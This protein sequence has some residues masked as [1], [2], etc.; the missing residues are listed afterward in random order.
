MDESGAALEGAEVVLMMWRHRPLVDM[1]AL[2]H[3]SH[4]GKFVCVSRVDAC[5]EKPHINVLW[6]RFGCP[7]EIAGSHHHPFAQNASIGRKAFDP[8][9]NLPVAYPLESEPEHL[10]DFLQVVEQ[11]FKVEGLRI[12]PPPPTQGSLL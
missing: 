6:R 9:G 4:G 5:P 3:V 11:A 2:L 12:L 1:T 8:F 7:P 10:R